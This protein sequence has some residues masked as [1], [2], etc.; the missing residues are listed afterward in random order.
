M[1][2]NLCFVLTQITVNLNGNVLLS[3]VDHVRGPVSRVST[4]RFNI[5]NYESGVNILKI[6][7]LTTVNETNDNAFISIILL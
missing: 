3:I 7:L 4:C 6:K 1:H 5:L 2:I